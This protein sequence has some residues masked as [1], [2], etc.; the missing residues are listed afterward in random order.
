MSS[1]APS[2]APQPAATQSTSKKAMER[3]KGTKIESVFTFVKIVQLVMALVILLQSVIR[4]FTTDNFHTFTG[5]VL[6]FYLVVFALALIAIE[7]DLFRAR[8]WF[9]FMNYSLGKCMFFFVMTLLCFGSGAQ[10]SWFDI[11]VG[12]VFGLV[13]VMYFFFFMMLRMG[14]SDDDDER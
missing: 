14:M 4:M 9:Y 3:L 5:F 6:T 12:V 8:V 13:T 1:Q 2:P 7:C 11:L 10:V